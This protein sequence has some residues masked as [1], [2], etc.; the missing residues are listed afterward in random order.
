MS[1]IAPVLRLA[2][3]FPWAVGIACLCIAAAATA[4]H[5]AGQRAELQRRKTRG[6]E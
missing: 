4:R 6:S 3:W 1:E 5:M 2:P